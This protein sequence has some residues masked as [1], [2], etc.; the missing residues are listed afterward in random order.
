[1]SKKPEWGAR[2][3]GAIS[4]D[5][6]ASQPWAISTAI[7]LDDIEVFEGLDNGHG[8]RLEIAFQNEWVVAWLDGAPVAMSPDLIWV[9]DTVSSEA[10]GT[11][12]IH[13]GWRVTVIVLPA[14]AG[15][16]DAERPRSRRPARVRL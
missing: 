10:C 13:Y 12:T 15:V 16:S 3:D 7:N 11:E 9:L 14:T 1:M 6:A 4:S 5:S 2:R 8:S